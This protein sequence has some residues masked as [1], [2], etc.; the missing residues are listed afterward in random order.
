MNKTSFKSALYEALHAVKQPILRLEDNSVAAYEFLSRS[1]LPGASMPDDFLRASRENQ[2]LE[3]TDLRCLENC[4][5][6]SL[7]VPN[8]VRR[9]LNLYPSTLATAP[10]EDI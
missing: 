10:I 5:A 2:T 1:S 9:H 4:I 8:G 6:A 7:R 3:S